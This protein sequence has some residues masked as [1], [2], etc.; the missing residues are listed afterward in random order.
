MPYYFIHMC[1]LKNKTKEETNRKTKWT[2][3]YREQMVN[4]GEVGRG[5]GEINEGD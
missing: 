2:L 3:K 1:N 5:I 4:R